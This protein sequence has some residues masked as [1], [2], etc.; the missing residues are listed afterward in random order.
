MAKLKRE[1]GGM[2]FSKREVPPRRGTTAATLGTLAAGYPLSLRAAE[3]TAQEK[4]NIQ[5]VNDFCEAWRTH[6]SPKSC[7]SSRIT[8]PIARSKRWK[9]PREGRPWRTRLSAS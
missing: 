1:G 3:P 5:V 8:A 9:L 2:N 6:D 4:A 7:S